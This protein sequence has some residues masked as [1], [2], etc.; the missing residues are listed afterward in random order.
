MNSTVA[1][2]VGKRRRWGWIFVV[3]FFLQ[4][5]FFLSM[6]VSADNRA[7]NYSVQSSVYNMPRMYS[8]AANAKQQADLALALLAIGS[9]VC[10]VGA[11]LGFRR[12]R[13]S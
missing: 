6:M 2:N 9:V 4:A 1:P 11:V 12:K 7:R 13:P 8:A 5:F 3:L 10:I